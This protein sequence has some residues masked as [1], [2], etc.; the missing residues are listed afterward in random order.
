MSHHLILHLSS[1]RHRSCH[2]YRP[3]RN[4]E[5]GQTWIA[6]RSAH[7]W[8]LSVFTPRIRRA[9]NFNIQHLGFSELMRH[10]QHLI[11][12]KLFSSSPKYMLCAFLGQQISETT[13]TQMK[14]VY[15]AKNLLEADPPYPLPNVR[16]GRVASRLT[17]KLVVDLYPGNAYRRSG[18]ASWTTISEFS[19]EETLLTRGR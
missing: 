6:P 13:C 7:L 17:C 8:T 2:P 16:I 15:P 5:R 14:T 10:T 12:L 18:E 19:Y 4:E 1:S 3:F 11:T 9:D